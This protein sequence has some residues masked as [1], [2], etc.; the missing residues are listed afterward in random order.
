[1]FVEKGETLYRSGDKSEAIFRVDDGLIGLVYTTKDGNDHLLRLFSKDQLVG[2]RTYYE[3]AGVYHATA[4]ALEKSHV[5]RI[6]IVEWEK[7]VVANP[8]IEK[9]ILKQLAIELRFAEESRIRLTEDDV[10]GR[11]AQALLYFNFKSPSYQWTRKEL[12]EW[13]GSTA[14]TVVR[15]LNR[16]SE[17]NWIKRV[18]RRII[19]TNTDVLKEVGCCSG[20]MRVETD[21]FKLK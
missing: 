3:G 4:I 8:K 11:V 17:K 18:G 14:P 21:R 12:A 20:T 19:L 10:E 9:E 2:H 16:F 6:P 7:A 13:I 1:M 15:V 5:E